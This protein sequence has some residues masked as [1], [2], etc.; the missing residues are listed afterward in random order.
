MDEQTLATDASS[1][2]LQQLRELRQAEEQ[3][4]AE[5]TAVRHHWLHAVEAL[6][7]AV[8]SWMLPAVQEGR[9]RLDAAVVHITEDD[10]GVYDAPAL[11]IAMPAGRIVWVRPVGTLRVGAQGIVDVVC[12]SSRA[13]MVLNRAGVW[14][15]R[16]PGPSAPL[17]ALDGYAFLRSLGELIL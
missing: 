5:S 6:L 13:L 14:K 17:A 16:G 2:F 1:A 9:V 7:A 15:I 4:D 12:G 11:K 10:V 8:R 3:S